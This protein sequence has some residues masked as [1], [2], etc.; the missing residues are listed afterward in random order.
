M[1]KNLEGIDQK[2]IDADFFTERGE[3][4]AILDKGIAATAAGENGAINIW[5]DRDGR[6]RC[7]AMRFCKSIEKE[8][9]DS[10]KD[11]QE[12][13]DKWLM[14]IGVS[15]KRRQPKATTNQRQRL[16]DY[17]KQEHDVML[18]DSDYNE[19]ENIIQP[20]QPLTD[21]M[22]EEEALDKYPDQWDSLDTIAAHQARDIFIKAAKWARD[23]KMKGNTT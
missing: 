20:I 6:I 8:V 18:L 7:E 10:D 23:F 15:K 17:F 9:F 19:I 21:D 12:W 1:L 14:D 16:F 11:V 5:K 22:I 4:K 3:I 13:A 2:E